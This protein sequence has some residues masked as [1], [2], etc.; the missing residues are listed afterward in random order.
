MSRELLLPRHLTLAPGNLTLTPRQIFHLGL[1]G[2]ATR[3]CCE[4]ASATGCG[5][6]LSQTKR[7]GLPSVGEPH[8]AEKAADG[9]HSKERRHEPQAPSQGPRA[10]TERRSRLRC[11]V[12]QPRIALRGCTMNGQGRRST[13]SRV[14]ERRIRV[15]VAVSTGWIGHGRGT[16]VGEIILPCLLRRG[17]A[18]ASSASRW[19]HRPGC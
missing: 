13:R 2:E 14:L 10:V 15:E 3:P 5:A 6:A 4:P 11:R 12:L 8:Q 9:P 19:Q 17:H 16:H 1:A 7:D 18:P